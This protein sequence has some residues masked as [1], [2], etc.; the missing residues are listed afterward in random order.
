MQLD[1]AAEEAPAPAPEQLVARADG[2]RQRLDR[3]GQFLSKD[4]S[5]MDPVTLAAL[6][7]ALEQAERAAE[8]R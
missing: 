7:R 3:I 4:A 8:I 5:G 1:M 6:E 2:I